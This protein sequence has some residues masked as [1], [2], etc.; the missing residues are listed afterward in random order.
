V[1]PS[2]LQKGEA[3]LKPCKEPYARK[4]PKRSGLR[5]AALRSVITSLLSLPLLAQPVLPQDQSKDQ[6]K[7]Q[8]TVSQTAAQMDEAW[9][10]ASAPYDQ[11]RDALLATVEKES[12]E[13][14]FQPDWQS[15]A[16]YQAP[17]WYRDAKFGIFI[18]WGLYSV[19]A[20]GSEWYPREMYLEG[21]NVNLHHV[22]TYGPLTK[23][24]YKDFIPMFKAEKFDPQAWAALF[25]E[26]GA[27]YVVPVF[28]HHDGFAMYDSDLSD[29]TAKKMGP[30]RDLVGELATAVRAQGMHLGASSHRIEHDWFLDGGRKQASDVNDPKY[31]AF[32]GPAHPRLGK[33]DAPLAEDWTYVSPAYA[34]DWVARNA[35]IVEKY[36][37]DLIFFD[38]WIGQ[39]MIR[40]YL[41]R[42][43]AY[44]YN[45]SSKRGPVG[46]INAKL[47]DMQETSA[48]LDIERG[49]LSSILPQPWQTD[50]S[51]SNKSWGYIENDTFKT[52][53]FIVQQLV[54]VVSK[55]GNLLLNVGPRSDGTIPQPVQQ[56][57]LDV[58][59]WLKV[60]GDAIYG[61]RP[62][63]TFGEGPTKVEA[64]SFHDTE[65]KPYTA[66][67]F[68]FTTK[69][70]TLYAIEMGWPA[71]GEAVIQALGSKVVGA[72]NVNAVSLLGAST[73]LEFSQQADGLHIKV[74]AEAPG[75]YAYAY[76]I[77]FEGVGH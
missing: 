42:F 65:T 47:V 37:P 72:R 31:A 32:Y 15:L 64:G 20:F 12:V 8:S 33:D 53:V 60:N 75:K 55:N 35:E 1:H 70:D 40:S 52:P 61:T 50:T 45:E 13:G 57:L 69:G 76:R 56:V 28:E 67:D 38:W 21:S 54:D 23:F 39:P 51:V 22:E 18:H 26:S 66:Q 34:N 10:K 41:T 7:D 6:S 24:G 27:R 62:W 58:G 77:G 44:Y 74:P 73:K 19:P 5:Q 46:I 11:R 9:Q 2:T 4:Y 48:V 68:R 43:A 49:Q 59:A 36:H 29:W 16:K 17:E 63:T 25:K 30:H 71:G 3:L 14:P